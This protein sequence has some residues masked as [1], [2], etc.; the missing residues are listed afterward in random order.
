MKDELEASIEVIIT[1]DG[2]IVVHR[3]RLPDLV[4]PVT[5]ERVGRN[6]ATADSYRA[7]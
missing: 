1:I 7:Q 6:L 2:D 3:E 5:D 4:A